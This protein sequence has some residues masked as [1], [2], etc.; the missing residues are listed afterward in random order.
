MSD[1]SP[2]SDRSGLTTSKIVFIVI[3]AAAPL[4][5]IVGTV[6]LMFARGNGAGV[7]GAYILAGVTLL[8]FA[9]GYAAM[10]RKVANSGAFYTY[11]AHGLG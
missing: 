9:L 1:E 3:A 4:A 6:P 10:A 8:L 7:P 5:A 2:D 11:V